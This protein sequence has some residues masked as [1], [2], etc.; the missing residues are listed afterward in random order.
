MDCIRVALKV[1]GIVQGV[2][3][4]PFVYRVALENGLTGWVIND[5]RGVEAELQGPAERVWNA[6]RQ[7]QNSPPPAAVVQTVKVSELPPADFGAFEIRES[8]GNAASDTL[9]IAPDLAICE[10]CRRELGDPANRRFRHPFITCTNCGPRYT[11][12]K[13][14]PYDRPRTTMAGFDMCGQCHFEYHD[15]ADR[16]HHAQPVAC[17]ECGPALQIFDGKG[18]PLKGDPIRVARRWLR[19]GRIVAVQGLGGFHLACLATRRR[20]VRKLRIRKG[21]ESRPLAVMVHDADLAGKFAGVDRQAD[22]L[23]RSP[24]APIVLLGGTGPLRLAPEVNVGSPSTGM[25]LA[26]TPLHL[27]LTE[28]LPPLVMTSANR[29]GE[30]MLTDP[31]E[32]MQSLRGVADAFLVHNRP[33]ARRCDDSV[34]SIVDGAVRVVRRGRGMVPRSL[35]IPA[36]SRPL[37]ACGAEQKNAFCLA[38]GNRAIMS[39]HV[40]DLKEQ[41]TLT[42][43]EREIE[44]LCALTKI[45]PSAVACDMHPDYLSSIYARRLP[46]PRV[47]V[48]HHHAHLASVLAEYC[49]YGQVLGVAFD[50]AGYGDDGQIWGG[51]FMMASPREYTRLGHL[52]AV[53]QP[54]G[55]LATMMPWRMAGSYLETCCPDEKRIWPRK[56]CEILRRA[57][58]PVIWQAACAGVA[59]PLT[60]SAGRLFDAV[61][62]ILGVCERSGY[63]GEAA[64][65]LESV[66]RPDSHSY[67]FGLI[68]REGLWIADPAPVLA[69]I[70]HDIHHGESVA[71][72]AGR[73]HQGMAALIGELCLVLR[74]ETGLDEVALSGGVFDNQ[75]LLRLTLRVLK[76]SGLRA[77]VNRQVPGN[78]GGIALGQ[79]LVAAINAG[80]AWGGGRVVSCSSWPSD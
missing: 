24:A 61:S 66:A 72:V 76:R 64:V 14:T 7:V 17:P 42:Q 8:N 35:S 46:L 63:E 27:L 65:R 54:G 40:G 71:D 79:A 52:A 44:S 4:R 74:D 20:A 32:S 37:L 29:S 22:A 16:R 11:I 77:L 41:A 53:P 51:E 21:R 67:H 15:P 39:A 26:Y 9:P 43:Y 10:A 68:C 45:W 55:D 6:V 50:G 28:D 1:N 57:E 59:G 47:E 38:E 69:E 62:A 12:V 2:G 49:R 31:G 3:F 23:L 34:M 80:N 19:L 36:A 18:R 13:D 70:L 33:I 78:D 60:S 48:Q 30:P 58:W 73:F 75:L 56:L 5:T 25:L